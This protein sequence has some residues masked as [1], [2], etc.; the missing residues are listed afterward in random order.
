MRPRLTLPR[1]LSNYPITY[2]DQKHII[3]A[4]PQRS[5]LP[6][7]PITFVRLEVKVVY[8]GEIELIHYV[9]SSVNCSGS[10]NV[11][12]TNVFCLNPNSIQSYNCKRHGVLGEISRPFHADIRSVFCGAIAV[13]CQCNMFIAPRNYSILLS[14]QM[15]HRIV[16]LVIQE[17]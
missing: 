15:P 3:K 4:I 17:V 9:K 6:V 8:K 16:E 5:P 12:L 2:T 1:G 14:T 10:I 7:P 13:S 11:A